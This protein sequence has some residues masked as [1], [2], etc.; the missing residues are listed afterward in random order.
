LSQL[1]DE[2]VIQFSFKTKAKKIA[3]DNNGVYTPL[4]YLLLLFTIIVFNNQNGNNII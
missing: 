1:L 4:L 3:L 2:A